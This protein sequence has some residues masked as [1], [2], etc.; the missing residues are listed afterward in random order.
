ML[1]KLI[2]GLRTGMFK[3]WSLMWDLSTGFYQ[4]SDGKV[5]QIVENLLWSS[6]EILARRI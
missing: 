2:R 5:E 4:K 3:G 1:E 6:K